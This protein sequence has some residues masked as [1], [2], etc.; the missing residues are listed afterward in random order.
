MMAVEVF[1]FC[2]KEG[3]DDPLWYCLY[4][5]KDAALDCEF[6]Q[7]AT[8]SGVNAGHNRRLIMPEQL[9]V[10]QIAVEMPDS[11]SPH[12]I[13]ARRTP[14]TNRNLSRSIIVRCCALVD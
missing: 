1:V 2:R 9:I 13:T 7:H 6:G 10:G 3:V 4:R 8:I 5:H 14:Q 11:T 12:T